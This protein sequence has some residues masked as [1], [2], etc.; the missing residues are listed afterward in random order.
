[1]IAAAEWLS[2]RSLQPPIG[3]VSVNLIAVAATTLDALCTLD[4]PSL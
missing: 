1:V 2:L 3:T 4:T